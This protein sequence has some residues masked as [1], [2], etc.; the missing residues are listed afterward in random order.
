MTEKT[1]TLATGQ[2]ITVRRPT[3]A[4]LLA[5]LDR[6]QIAMA[7]ERASADLTDDGDH[8]LQACVTSPPPAEMAE[9]LED[10]PLLNRHLRDAVMEL[11]GAGVGF[12]RDDSRVTAQHRGAGRR[13][14]AYVV[15]VEQGG[16]QPVRKTDGQT[17]ETDEELQVRIAEWQRARERVLVLTK[18]SRYEVKA[19]E[20][21]AQ[22]QGHKG[23]LPSVLA[24]LARQHVVSL[25]GE[26]E[27]TKELLL[28]MPLLIA[29]LGLQLFAAA[30][31]KLL[32]VEGKSLAAT[33]KPAESATASAPTSS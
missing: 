20:Q 9:L 19:L 11:S 22:E 32:E 28:Q 23:P 6:R 4:E 8:Q 3:E 30:S 12:R 5:Y 10:Y 17:H 25:P 16:P 24:K 26:Q 33:S 13:L 18:L 21:E 7:G 1:L 14:V 15:T 2:T 31:V 29:N 27:A